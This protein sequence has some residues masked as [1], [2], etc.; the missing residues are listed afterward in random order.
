MFVILTF[1]AFGA[2]L[3]EQVTAMSFSPRENSEMWR[4]VDLRFSDD[5]IQR[6]TLQNSHEQIEYPLEPVFTAGVRITSI[7]H[8]SGNN[9]GSSELW[10]LSDPE[11]EYYIAKDCS[12][13]H[14]RA[15]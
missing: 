12:L 14:S 13:S 15:S 5:T 11:S 3:N 1:S 4:D 10:F 2:P 9:I 8:Y 6:I 7:T